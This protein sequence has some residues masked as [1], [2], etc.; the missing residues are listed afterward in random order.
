VARHVFIIVNDPP[1]AEQ[2]DAFDHWYVDRHMP[3]VLDV[4]GF[5]SAQR[6]RLAP[7]PA[8]PEA[9]PRY[10]AIYEI[11]TDDRA[12]VMAEL[13]RRAGTEKMPLFPGPQRSATAVFIGEAVTPRLV[14]K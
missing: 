14:A 6:F 2:V 7:E 5:I 12:A 3:D 10:L 4:P 13:R 1:S 8:H 11:E 9:L